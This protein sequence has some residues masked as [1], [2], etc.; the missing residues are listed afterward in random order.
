MKLVREV[1]AQA[2][3]PVQICVLAWWILACFLQLIFGAPPSAV[4]IDH[5]TQLILLVLL[6]VSAAVCLAGSLLGDVILGFALELWGWAGICL[7]FVIYGVVVVA[8][9]NN[10]QSGMTAILFPAFIIGGS[11]RIIQIR[12]AQRRL[13][14]I[15][16]HE[17]D[18]LL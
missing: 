2:R 15:E 12:H 3:H 18:P 14:K 6:L 10:M 7:L 1:K 4:V 16:R 5:V 11:W 17:I 13:R 9:S 8:A